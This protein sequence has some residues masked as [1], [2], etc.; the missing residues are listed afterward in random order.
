MSQNGR[1]TAFLDR[2]PVWLLHVFVVG[3]ALHN[4]VAAELYHAGL[5][6]NALEAVSSWKELLLALGLVLVWR[7][8]GYPHRFRPTRLD[9]LALAFGAFVVVYA[10]I[11]Q[12]ALGGGATHRGIALAARHDLLP[13]AAYFFGRALPLTTADVRRVG[14]T[15]ILVACGVAAFGIVDI[16]AIPLTYWRHT[17]IGWFT[18]QLGFDYKGTGLSGLPQ[19]FIYNTGNEIPLRRLVSTFLSPLATSYFLVVALLLAASWRLATHARLRVWA[20]VVAL[21]VVALLLTHSRSSM[22]ALALALLAFAVVRPQWRV[23]LVAAAVATVVLSVAFVKVYGHVAP[24]TSFTT[25]ELKEQRAHAH[26]AAGGQAVSGFQDASTESHLQ[27]LRDGLRTDFHHPWGFG[28]GNAGSTAARTKVTI[29]AGES[30]YT[31]LGAETGIVGGLL[32]VAWSLGLLVG[33]LRGAAWLGAS[34][35]ALLA[36]GLQTDIIGVPWLVFVVWTLAGWCVTT[37]DRSS[38]AP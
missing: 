30:S 15:I 3:L 4:L 36:L 17:A 10:V 2:K 9:W 21:L 37:R 19:N 24:T 16:Y 28:L 7:Q 31:E 35:L 8:A 33:T 20:P 18:T 14:A 38:V 27:S 25:A 5:R 23:P 13:V 11:P 34:F 26:S 6:G 32:F 12:S 29:E 1:F 22:L